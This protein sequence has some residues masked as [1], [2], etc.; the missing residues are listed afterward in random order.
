MKPAPT[1]L[2]QRPPPEFV[3]ANGYT[4]ANQE[5]AANAP[6][7]ELMARALREARGDEAQARGIYVQ[8]RARQL[9]Q[10]ARVPPAD[11]DPPRPTRPVKAARD[12]TTHWESWVT[13]GIALLVTGTSVIS[14]VKVLG[15]G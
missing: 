15:G 2:G 7:P 1:A 11:A 8:E 14:A 13:L 5:L 9:A 6:D 3:W 12:R 4:L 10:V